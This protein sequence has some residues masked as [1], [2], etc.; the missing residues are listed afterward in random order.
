MRYV[1]RRLLFYLVAFWAT[2]SLNFVLPRLMPGNP[3]EALMAKFSGRLNPY[4]LHA[5]EI[6][7]GLHQHLSLWQQYVQYL[8]NLAH[9]NLGVSL[10]FFPQPVTQVIFRA[11]PW[12]LGLV[13]TATIL[14]FLGGII[15]GALAAWRHGRWFDS[16]SSTFFTFSYAFPYF[17]VALL[18]VYFMGLVWGLLPL[19]GAYSNSLVPGWSWAFVGNVLAHAILPG[20]TIVL[21]SLGYWVLNMRN[22]MIGTLGEDYVIAAQSRGLTARQILVQYAGRNAMLPNLTGFAMSL[23]FIVAGSILTEIVF[24]YPGVG[25]L[26]YQAVQQED[27]PLIQGLL[28]VITIAVLAA[29][30]VADIAYAYLDPRISQER[31]S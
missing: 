8:E 24:S 9:G 28:L 17:W 4:E 10:T 26:L 11:L 27:Y 25:Y 13:G 30:L 16:L 23:G 29:N 1:L 14:S 18:A 3:A 31:E 19:S 5:I 21:T 2:I 7:F 15:M 22:T 6:A 12:T 20:A